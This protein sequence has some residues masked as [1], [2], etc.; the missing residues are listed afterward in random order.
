MTLLVLSPLY[1]GSKIIMSSASTTRPSAF[2]AWIMASRPKTMAA[3]IVP[4]L[5]G[6]ALA[7]SDGYFA[8]LPALAALVGASLIQVGTNFANDYFD[9]QKGA[10]NDDRL[11]PT[12]VVQSGII[13]AK[14]V[15]AATILTFA[16]AALIGVYLIWVAGWPILAIGVASILSGIAYTGGPYPL[17]YNGLGDV[18]VFIFFGLIAV[19]ATYYVQALEWSTLSLLASIPVGFLS[20][21]ILVVNNYRDIDTD[22][23]AGKN[24]LAVRFGRRAARM[25]Y[26]ILVLLSYAIPPLHIL[27]FGANAWVLLPLLTLPVAIFRVRAIWRKTGRA[28]NPLLAQ[29]AQLLIFFGILYTIGIAL[30]GGS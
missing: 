10:D 26:A 12:R 7:L 2:R 30:A 5:V 9:H 17:G 14:K 3:A 15:R 23:V 27:Y 22:R 19:S 29:T 24:T 11:G 1:A 8:W 25:Q 6:S 20:T 4:V 21:A 16:L 13:S 18:F 28:L